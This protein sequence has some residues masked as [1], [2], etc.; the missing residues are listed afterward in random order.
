[1]Q[2]QKQ[3]LKCS[4]LRGKTQLTDHNLKNRTKISFLPYAQGPCDERGPRVFPPLPQSRG[5]RGPVGAGQWPTAR[6]HTAQLLQSWPHTRAAQENRG[7]H[8]PR[9]VPPGQKATLLN[10]N[11]YMGCDPLDSSRNQSSRPEHRSTSSYLH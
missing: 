10:R 9:T 3:K 11:D 7:L 4:T 5:P 8:P 1:M 2:K 6:R